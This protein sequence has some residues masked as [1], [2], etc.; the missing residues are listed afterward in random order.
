MDAEAKSLAAL[1]D[2]DLS[3]ARRAPAEARDVYFL[4]MA[5]IAPTDR[6]RRSLLR[7][8]E[9]CGFE[10]RLA[11]KSRECLSESWELLARVNAILSGRPA[12]RSVSKEPGLQRG[13]LREAVQRVFDRWIDEKASPLPRSTS[14]H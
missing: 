3:W 11:E 5:E 7:H 9:S 2:G 4:R 14:M 8:A 13:L 12:E 10:A 6:V 1:R